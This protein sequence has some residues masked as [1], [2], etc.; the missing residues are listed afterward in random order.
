MGSLL[1]TQRFHPQHCTN[2][3]WRLFK[4]P[5][6]MHVSFYRTEH[7]RGPQLSRT[8]S[9][10]RFA[11][12]PLRRRPCACLNGSFRSQNGNPPPPSIRCPGKESPHDPTRPQPRTAHPH[13]CRQGARG[14]DHS[15]Q[16]AQPG[17][18]YRRAGRLRPAGADL[19]RVWLR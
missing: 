7:M 3:F 10:G 13:R 11:L 9:G 18:L 15:Y 16:A 5:S 12:Q 1:S 6:S 17:D 8:S 2:C 19:G 4:H 14:G